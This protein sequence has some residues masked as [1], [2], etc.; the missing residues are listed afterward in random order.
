MS[1]S[2]RF[3]I[4]DV[5]RVILYSAKRGGSFP[6][7]WAVLKEADMSTQPILFWKNSETGLK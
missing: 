6:A 1:A 3:R 4:F 5:A 2:A 7:V